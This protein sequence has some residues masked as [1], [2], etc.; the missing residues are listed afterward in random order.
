MM[1]D[2]GHHC[3]KLNIK[4]K[5]ENIICLRSDWLDDADSMYKDVCCLKL[6]LC[7]Y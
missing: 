6:S 3:L 1:F 7:M 4:N 5:N 2:N